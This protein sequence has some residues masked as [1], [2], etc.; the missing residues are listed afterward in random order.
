[1][2]LISPNYERIE[3]FSV[4]LVED[5]SLAGFTWFFNISHMLGR[6][7]KFKKR[8]ILHVQKSYMKNPKSL[9]IITCWAYTGEKAIVMTPA[10]EGIFE[11]IEFFISIKLNFVIALIFSELAGKEE[12]FLLCNATLDTQKLTE[13]SSF[14]T[15]M[16][17]LE[18]LDCE[19][20]PSFKIITWNCPS[21]QNHNK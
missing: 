17:I 20:Y 15:N 5:G 10:F 6:S 8:R 9:F 3:I 16:T 2:P 21:I 14:L 13:S 12:L 7:Q 11:Q 19:L 18:K 1:M 4:F